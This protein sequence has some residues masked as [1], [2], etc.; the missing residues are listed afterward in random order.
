MDDMTKTYLSA[1]IS[2]K[3]AELVHS[4][5]HPA[6]ICDKEKSILV[7]TIT[8][9]TDA[10]V[11]PG[12]RQKGRVKKAF[13]ALVEAIARMSFVPGGIH[14]FGMHFEST[15]EGS[16]QICVGDRV[17]YTSTWLRSVGIYTG[18]IPFYKGVVTKE[19]HMGDARVL[20]VHW[21]GIPSEQC[22]YCGGVGCDQCNHTGYRYPHILDKNLERV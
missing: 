8:E 12:H 15:W 13:L 20:E 16:I 9:C 21:D 5:I 3:I 19:M 22:Y 1:A 6:D 2:M 14:I 4:D 7:D 17:G 18:D 11:A 10:I